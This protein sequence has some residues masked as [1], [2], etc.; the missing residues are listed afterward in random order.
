MLITLIRVIKSGGLCGPVE[1]NHILKEADNNHKDFLHKL[2]T[3]RES[4]LTQVQ[5]QQNNVTN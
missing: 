3:Y 5:N 4:K 1:D 2:Y